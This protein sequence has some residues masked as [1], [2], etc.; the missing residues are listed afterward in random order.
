M[1][2]K[3]INDYLNKLSIAEKI[4][5]PIFRIEYPYSYV[6]NHILYFSKVPII[7]PSLE[8]EYKYKKVN[9][10]ELLGGKNVFTSKTKI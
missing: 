8:D 7:R 1:S 4:F 5:D 10:N 2:K 6:E 3:Q 9:V